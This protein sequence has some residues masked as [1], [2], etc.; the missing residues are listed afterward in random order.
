[1]FEMWRDLHL[2]EFFGDDQDTGV[3]LGSFQLFGMPMVLYHL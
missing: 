3:C 1:M 2:P